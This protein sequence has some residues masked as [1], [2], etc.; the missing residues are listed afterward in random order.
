MIIE[1]EVHGGLTEAFAIAMGQEIRYDETGNVVTGSFMD[2]FM[3][4]AVEA[5]HWETHFTV[6]PS[7]HHPIGSK[8]VGDSPDVGA[9]PGVA[10]GA[11]D[12][13]SSLGSPHIPRPDDYCRD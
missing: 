12:A 7:P 13:F 1:G 10:N 2:F 5:P 9:L 11:N 3:P 6:T 8:G 4:T